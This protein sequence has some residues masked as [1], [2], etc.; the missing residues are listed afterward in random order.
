MNPELGK[1]ALPVNMPSAN[2][3]ASVELLTFDACSL[4]QEAAG[5]DVLA[6]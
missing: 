2:Q 4:Q 1:Q 5:T 6:P 3:G